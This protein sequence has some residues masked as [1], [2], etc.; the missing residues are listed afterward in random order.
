[1]VADRET[2]FVEKICLP[3]LE[4]AQNTDGGWGFHSRSES[5][6]E[7]TCWA[8]QALRARFGND[9]SGS[10]TRGYEY[11]RMAQLPDGSW[12]STPKDEV[13]CWVTS[14][15]CLVLDPVGDSSS[16]FVAGLRW[17]CQDWPADT[18][19]WRRLL[20]RLSSQS[21][22]APVNHSYRGWGWTPGTSSWVEPTAFA[23]LALEHAVGGELPQAAAKRRE[24]GEA[25]LYDRMCPGGGWN[26][27]NPSVY[28]VPGEPLVGPTTWALIA[29][30]GH[31]ERR[32]NV[33]SMD[34]LS[35]SVP[36]IQS[37][38]SLASAKVCME[39]YGRRW[40]EDAPLFQD[41]HDRNGFL[42]STQV[43]AWTCLAL[44]ERAKWL[45]RTGPGP[46]R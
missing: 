37:A 40:P 34:W 17:I 28:G 6:V 13:G 9:K 39:A 38:A 42:N 44:M 12:P 10:I 4:N 45:D 27:G 16:N 3:F 43:A 31:P 5:R 15:A 23:L 24:L 30:R 11:I 26:C 35:R 14:L 25:L 29:L 21:D 7:P 22:V 33:E 36:T 46:K 32:Q 2:S 19:P 41:L 18:T 8:L 20:A 1:M